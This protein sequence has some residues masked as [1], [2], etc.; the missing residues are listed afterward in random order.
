MKTIRERY[1]ALPRPVGD[2]PHLYLHQLCHNFTNRLTESV[3]GIN[4]K[5][6]LSLMIEE[7][8]RRLLESLKF[9]VA[10]FGLADYDEK[11]RGIL[12]KSANDFLLEKPGNISENDTG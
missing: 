4:D 6:D 7:A 8:D 3:K 11:K 5:K 9:S 10:Q 12:T 2:A 1:R